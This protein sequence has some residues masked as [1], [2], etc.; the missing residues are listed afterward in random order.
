RR[1][2]VLLIDPPK[3][4]LPLLP[5]IQARGMRVLQVPQA[6]FS[7]YA[8]HDDASAAL[9]D[10]S[11]LGAPLSLSLEGVSYREL[12][13]EQLSWVWRTAPSQLIEIE[14][15][16]RRLIATNKVVAILRGS[17]GEG[18]AHIVNR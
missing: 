6:Y 9:D 11:V 5:S 2:A 8:R 18:P 13:Q 12:V 1:P 15:R 17:A 10:I 14:R 4:W 16:M 3:D 7:T